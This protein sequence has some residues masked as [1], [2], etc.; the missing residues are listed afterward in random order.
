MVGVAAAAVLVS[1]ERRAVV[2]AKARW[3]TVAAT[4]ALVA[5]VALWIAATPG[6][7][8]L[9]RGLLPLTATCSL[10]LVVGAL[11]P[12]GPVASIASARPLRWLGG[13]SYALYLVHWPVDRRRRPPDRQPIARPGRS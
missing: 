8:L 1:A 13:I 3:L 2:L 9:R 5:T 4:G 6:T 10:L 11:L 12:S 7:E